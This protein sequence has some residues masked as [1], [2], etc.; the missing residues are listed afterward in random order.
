MTLQEIHDA[1]AKIGCLTMT[2]M[3]NNTMHSRIISVCGGD[4]DGLY[5]LTMNVKP[6]YRQLK[7]NPHIAVCGIYPTSRKDGKNSAG[8][9][10]FPPGFTLRISGEAREVPM[11]EVERQAA[12]GSAAHQYALE[13]IERYPAMRLFCIHKGK[14]EMFDFDFEMEH[15]DHKLLRTRF[16]FGG[17]SVNPAGAGINPER[18]I[19]CGEC[20]DACSF[21]AIHPGTPYSVDGARCDECGD[22][23]VVCPEDA[24]E[25]SSTL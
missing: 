3:D 2:T 24:V 16:A 15:R 4:E 19:A 14:G 6:F 13:D 5:F 23:S 20:F 21:K 12:Q 8:Q 7:A 1:V 9:P 18:C 11:D 17:E 25:L 10:Y 22:C